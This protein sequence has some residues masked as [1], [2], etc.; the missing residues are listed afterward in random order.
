MFRKYA[1]AAAAMNGRVQSAPPQGWFAAAD[2]A[3][4]LG[5]GNISVSVSVI[6]N[7]F[8]LTCNKIMSFR[9]GG[10]A[11]PVLMTSA[12][13]FSQNAPGNANYWRFSPIYLQLGRIALFFP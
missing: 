9:V 5:A 2:G 8:M 12:L 4:V 1:I 13:G 10:Q 6:K 3:S 11:L 7:S